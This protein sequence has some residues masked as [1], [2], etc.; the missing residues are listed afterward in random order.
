MGGPRHPRPA[1]L[2]REPQVNSGMMA[3]MAFPSKRRRWTALLPVVLAAATAA[4]PA[5]PASP[6]EATAAID[7]GRYLGRW[8][9]IARAPATAPH[10]R[11]AYFEYRTGAGGAIQAVYAAREDSFDVEPVLVEHAVSADPAAPAR[12]RVRTGWFGSDER[13]VLYVSPDYQYTIT[14][15]PD[16][17][18][19][20]IL[21]REPEIPEWSY[22]GL[23]ARLALQGYDVAAFRRVP[24]KPEQVGRP[25]FE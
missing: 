25:G 2:R 7:L 17:D 20:W 24:H 3:A 9:V 18:E 10:P 5:P 11:G 12:W 13:W 19:A 22:A 4:V 16:H 1:A 6:A 23:L 14:G 8:Y 21:A 15:T